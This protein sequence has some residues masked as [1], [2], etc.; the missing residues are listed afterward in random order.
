M[1]SFN[2]VVDMSEICGASGDISASMDEFKGCLTETGL[3]TLPMQGN[4]FTW[5]N[6][7]TDSRSLWK[8]L[9]RMLVNDR[10]LELWP[11]THYVSLNP[12]T[13]DH[14][15]LV[16]K[17]ELQN[18]PVILFRLDNYLASSP[19]F[20][21]MVHSILRNQVVGTSMYSVT[22]K[23]KALKP[24]FRQQRKKKG[25]LSQNVKQAKDFWDVAQN[26]LDTDRHNTLLIR[27]EHCCRLVY[28]K[29]VKLEQCMLQQR[30]KIQWLKGGDQCSKVLF[31]R[32]ATRRASMH[33]FQIND[34]AGHTITNSDEVVAEFIVFYEQLLG[35]VFIQWVEECVTTPTFSVCINGSAHDFFKGAQGLR[36]GDPMSPYLF[37]LVI[38]VL[39]RVQLIKSVLMA[40]NTYWAMAFILPKGII[41]EIEKR[42]RN[43]LRKGVAGTSYSKVAW[44]QVCNPVDEG[45]LGVRDF[46]SLNLALMS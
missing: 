26:L 45:G 8:R 29:V 28:L 25:D 17:G 22:R 33:V 15:H 14:S 23:L 41:K 35:E 13:L 37:V 6:C 39:P 7:S 44:S 27:L 46:Q 3:I 31:R 32:V 21:P 24:L 1:G 16:L 5:H 11:G 4:T 19:N 30:A 12:R 18:P 10:W 38:E 42:L 40:L 43:I 2:T 36:W 9:D 20:I 34:D